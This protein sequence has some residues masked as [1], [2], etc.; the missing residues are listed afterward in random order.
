LT[1]AGH[2]HHE[3]AH[4]WLNDLTGDLRLCFCRFTQLGLLRLLTAAA[5]MG[6]DALSQAEAWSVYD[7]VRR[8]YRV[9]M[10]E[11]HD[12]LERRV[13]SLTRSK[14]AAPRTWADAYLA[15]FADTSHFSLVT[16]DRALRGRV[17]SL[18]LLVP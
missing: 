9:I 13:R 7:G 6:D 8:D 10:A 4:D 1:H 11:E 17:T 18:V 3:V 12:A 15:A 14:H 5:V 16:F 2:V